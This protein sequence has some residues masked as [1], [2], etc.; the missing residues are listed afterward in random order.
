MKVICSLVDGP[1]DKD[2]GAVVE[3][4]MSLSARAQDYS[5]R[6]CLRENYP[7]AL[8]PL[9]VY[10]SQ[11]HFARVFGAWTRPAP[12]AGKIPDGKWKPVTMNKP[13]L[14]V[15]VLFALQAVTWAAIK[16]VCEGL[17]S[18]IPAAPKSQ[19]DARSRSDWEQWLCAENVEITKCFE[20]GTFEIVDLPPG[21]KEL[22]SMWQY[23]L[24]TGPSGEFVKCKARLVARGDLQFDYEYGETFAPTSRFSVVRLLIAI[25]TQAGHTCINSM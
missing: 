6:R 15:A 4:Y 3:I 7:S 19:R 1:V 20:K 17:E 2:K 11:A 18:P 9:Q 8:T 21:V 10:E 24:K 23:A 14:A 16:G 22:P 25:A 5:I 13:S 12:A